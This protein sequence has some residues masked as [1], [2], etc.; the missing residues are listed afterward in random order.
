MVIQDMIYLI[1]VEGLT[2]YVQS[3]LDLPQQMIFVD[4]EQ[5]PPK[6][7]TQPEQN[8]LASQ[9]LSIQKFFSSIFS[10]NGTNKDIFPEECLPMNGQERES[11][12]QA[13]STLAHL[14][15]P[16]VSESSKVVDLSNCMQDT[17]VTLPTLNGWL[18]GY[19]VVYLS[20]KEHMA[21]AVYNLSTKPLNLF[22]IVVG[23]FD[24]CY[25]PQK[26]LTFC[27]DKAGYENAPQLFSCRN[28]QLTKGPR[29]EELMRWV[30]LVMLVGLTYA[31]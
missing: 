14:G 22:K 31:I 12:K 2:E 15:E 20:G 7:V 4:L 6:M 29:P 10:A 8:M 19:P 26:L 5:D 13:G 27:L 23:R 17:D 21:D 30:F 1:H 9:L 25:S 11:A 18:L 16:V 24:F 3:S 28:K